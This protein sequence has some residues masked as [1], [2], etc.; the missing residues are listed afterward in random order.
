VTL[1]PH[2][3][4]S[5]LAVI[6]P[7]PNAGPQII[8]IQRLSPYRHFRLIINT[9]CIICWINYPFSNHGLGDSRKP[10]HTVPLGVVK[11]YQVRKRATSAF[12][13]VCLSDAPPLENEVDGSLVLCVEND[14]VKT[15]PGVEAT[16]RMCQEEALLRRITNNPCDREAVGG[17]HLESPDRE[18]CQTTN[19][20][21]E[22]GEGTITDVI[23]IALEKHWL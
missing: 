10:V 4:L 17:L 3:F 5:K 12:C 21:I 2:D 14:D 7:P 15:W 13:G 6:A 9:S 19:T 23:N 8:I 16:C 18:T 22:M 11:M 20:F 1:D